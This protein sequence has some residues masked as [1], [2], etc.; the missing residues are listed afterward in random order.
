MRAE[1]RRRIAALNETKRQTGSVWLQISTS[2][3]RVRQLLLPNALIFGV[4]KPQ[5]A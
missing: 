3:G 2:K 5:Q 4:S 1:I